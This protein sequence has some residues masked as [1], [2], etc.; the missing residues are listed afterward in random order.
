[1]GQIGQKNGYPVSLLDTARGQKI[2]DAISGIFYLGKGA[3]GII[4]DGVYLIGVVAGRLI[5]YGIQRLFVSGNFMGDIFRPIGCR[6]GYGC[7]LNLLWLGVAEKASFKVNN[8][9]SAYNELRLSCQTTSHLNPPPCGL[10]LNG[11]VTPQSGIHANFI[12]LRCSKS[13]FK[14]SI[15]QNGWRTALLRKNPEIINTQKIQFL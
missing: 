8:L 14:M 11:C 2:G 15:R 9:S 6:P 10:S 12:I 5:K 4:E 3:G 1:V 13:L 7:H